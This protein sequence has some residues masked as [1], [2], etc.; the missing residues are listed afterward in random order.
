[1]KKK[2]AVLLTGIMTASLLL[3][4][5]QS[6]KGIENDNLKISQYKGV[7][8]DEVDKADDVTDKDV[9]GFIDSVRES[10][11][12]TKTIKNRAVKKGD[13]VTID[14]V[15][16]MNGKKFDNGSANNQK[17]KIGSNTFIEGFEDSIIGHKVGDKFVWNGKF[18]KNYSE[19]L[20]GKKVSFTIKVKAITE[21]KTPELN[22]AFVKKV[23]SKSKTV[24][25][26]KKEVKK[27]LEQ[28]AQDQADSSLR[29]TAWNTVY[30]N[31]EVVE[32]P[33]KDVE[34]A[35]KTFKKQAEAYAK[36]GNMELED[37]V[38][39]QGVSMDD[40]EAQCQ[41]YAQAKVKQNL[42]IQGIMDAEGMTLEDE[43][44][45]AIQNQ[46]VEQYASGDLA[47]LIDTYGQVTVDESIGLMRVQDFII[48]NA[49]YDQTAADTSAEGEDAQAAEG[50][51]AADHADG[52]TTDGQ[53]TD[54]GDTAEEQEAGATADTG[55]AADASTDTQDDSTEN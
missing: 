45:L 43:E 39:S 34:E 6:S 22:D 26:Y 15:G 42:L 50:T 19:E 40:F 48:A 33:E 46:L 28:E 38:E 27:K 51:E 30:T 16:K 37:F 10:N 23:S 21:S 31:S 9:T 13:T 36:Q 52:S 25:E 14:F 49:N 1:M 18:P 47:V 55:T 3:S 8:I 12:K 4:G 5:C 29:S 24:A 17:L 32:Y 7:E 54:G 53:S 20:A 11:A 44:S 2:A 41:Q 35:V